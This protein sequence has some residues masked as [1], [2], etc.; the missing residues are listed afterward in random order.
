MAAC[1]LP[2]VVAIGHETDFTIAEFTADL[3]A[4]TPSAA[5]ELIT[6]DRADIER[7]L[8]MRF[9]HL[10][11]SMRHRLTL[12]SHRLDASVARL[13]DPRE[14]LRQLMQRADDIET[15]LQRAATVTVQTRQLRS[16]NLA[17]RLSAQHPSARLRAHT[18]R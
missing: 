14:R 2:T 1:A 10:S 4:A 8:L 15:R 16:R 9:A 12:A 18:P 17:E 7:Q 5:A 3:R 11:Q 6:P 13:R